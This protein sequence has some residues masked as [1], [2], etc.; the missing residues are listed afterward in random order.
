MAGPCPL[1]AGLPLLSMSMVQGTQCK[2]REAEKGSS[3]ALSPPGARLGGVG[4]VGH[5]V[6]EASSHCCLQLASAAKKKEGRGAAASPSI[7]TFKFHFLSQPFFLV[8]N[9]HLLQDVKNI[10]PGINC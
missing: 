7:T 10:L 3:W 2:G 6:A 5:L 8:A 4:L 1:E 9:Y